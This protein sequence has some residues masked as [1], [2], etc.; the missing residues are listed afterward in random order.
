VTYAP[1][2]LRCPDHSGK[3]L[4]KAKVAAAV[5]VRGDDLVT[6]LLIALNV[7]VFLAE[8]A[9]GGS[10]SG[11]GGSTLATRLA[12]DGPDVANGDWYR[13]LT[14]GFIH[15]GIWH[16]AMNMYALYI[17]GGSLERLMGRGRFLLVYL[18]SLV[19]GSTGALL[20]TSCGLTGGAS[21][22]IFGLLGAAL[23]L[24]RQRV[25]AGGNVVGVLVLNLAFTL[26]VPGISIGGHLGGLVA[27]VVVTLL[28]SRFGRGHALY[29]RLGAL[30]IA[31]PLAVAGAS[32]AL[33]IW[34]AHNVHS[35]FTG[36]WSF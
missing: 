18:V 33:G 31:G 17:L 14:A 35:C 28:L 10:L 6:R 13:L 21:G 23:V 11:F 1:V 5:G 4:G 9:T 30:G 34:S 7:G 19:A 29:G 2:G 26:G 25:I 12:V 32:I 24:E 3:P 16:I 22:A 36:F 20:I 15:Y 8:I 27:G